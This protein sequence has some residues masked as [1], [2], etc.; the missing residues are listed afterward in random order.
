VAR[1]DLIKSSKF[2]SLLL[3]HNPGKI[4]LKLDE[5]GWAKVSD[6]IVLMPITMSQLDYMVA[7][8]KKKRYVFNDDKSKIRANQGHSIAVDLELKPVQPPDLLF[9]G[10][11]SKFVLSIIKHGLLKGTRQHVHLSED[12]ETAISVGKRHGGDVWVFD[13]LADVMFDAGYKFFLSENGVWL[14]DHVPSEFLIK[15]ELYF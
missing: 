3:R 9:H 7:V 8:D 14:I 2:L 10:T 6:L 4:G 12:T 1:F 5:H 15:R 11:S 13:V